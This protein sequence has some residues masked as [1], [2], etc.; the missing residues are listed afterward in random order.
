MG[1]DTK[2]NRAFALM[3]VHRPFIEVADPPISNLII[4]SQ[5]EYKSIVNR[6]KIQFK[7]NNQEVVKLKTLINRKY[8]LKFKEDG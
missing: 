1:G 7:L 8:T 5:E 3:C 2:L 6:L 4:L